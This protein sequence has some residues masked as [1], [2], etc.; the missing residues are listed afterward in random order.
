M[1]SENM[2]QIITVLIIISSCLILLRIL[3]KIAWRLAKIFGLMVR[4]ILVLAILLLSIMLSATSCQ[5]SSCQQQTTTIELLISA[6]C[7]NDSVPPGLRTKSMNITTNEW[8]QVCSILQALEFQC[9]D[10]TASKFS[11]RRND[12]NSPN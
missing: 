6:L 8:K 9:P 11:Q 5:A 4:S 12:T 10:T 7:Q 2:A 3:F 1:Q